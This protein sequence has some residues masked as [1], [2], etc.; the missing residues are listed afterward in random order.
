[1]AGEWKDL[2][3]AE[4]IP[5]GG[6][7]PIV[8][9]VA[10]EGFGKTDGNILALRGRPYRAAHKVDRIRREG[11][12]WR[13]TCYFHNDIQ[14]PGF[15]LDEGLRPWPERCDA[16]E[17]SLDIDV[18]GTLNLPWERNIRC[19]PEGWERTTLGDEVRDG[20]KI[21]VSWV[22]DNEDA[23]DG[24]QIQRVSVRATATRKAEEAVF[25]AEKDGMWDGSFEDFTQ[26]AADIEG[27]LAAP[28]EY[29]NDV[30]HKSNRVRRAGKSIIESFSSRTPGR[31]GM[32]DPDGARAER[33]LEELIDAIARAVRET[34]AGAPATTIRTFPSD[35]DLYAIAAQLG[36]DVSALIA[37]N[38][39]LEDI[40][41]IP[42]GTI[43]LVYAE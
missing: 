18:T 11:K 8:L 20:E 32:R 28:G 22:E 2:L 36:Q 7:D 37:L 42:T 6:G 34:Q 39:H 15:S 23:L 17:S 10:I 24:S 43:V 30:E 35:R 26:L 12:R 29:L 21:V 14:Q 27:T 31:D 4:W 3:P 16:F 38:T 9:A 5:P 33:K 13:T 1:M 41:H 25:D 19:F 40:L